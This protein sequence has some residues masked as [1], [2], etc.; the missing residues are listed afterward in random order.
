[1]D[2]NKKVMYNS[3]EFAVKNEM[4]TDQEIES[5]REGKAVLQGHRFKPTYMKCEGLGYTNGSIVHLYKHRRLDI[6]SNK[7]LGLPP[8]SPKSIFDKK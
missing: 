4:L 3:L 8:I 2:P 7:I 1:M 6:M 5:I